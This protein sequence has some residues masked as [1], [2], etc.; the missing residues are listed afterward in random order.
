V[1]ES[2]RNVII[3]LICRYLHV[4]VS[5][6]SEPVPA[7]RYD[8]YEVFVMFHV[9]RIFLYFYFILHTQNSVI[10]LKSAVLRV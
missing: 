4:C 5:L 9:T 6:V 3:V 10:F 2:V 8:V 1:P 7:V